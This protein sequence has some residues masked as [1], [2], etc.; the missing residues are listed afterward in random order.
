MMNNKPFL[1]RSWRLF[2]AACLVVALAACSKNEAPP[3]DDGGGGDGGDDYPYETAAPVR[4][5]RIGWDYSTRERLCPLPGRVIQYSSYPR[6]KLLSDGTLACIYEVNQGIEFIRQ[7]ADGEWRSPV[8]L[9]S[10]TYGM[11]YCVPELLELSDGTLLGMY[12]PRPTIEDV[13]RKFAIHTKRSAD[14]GATW[15]DHRVVYEASHKGIDGCWEP[16][17]IELPDGEVQL[18]FANEAPYTASSEQEIS[19]CSSR[20]G[21]LS[22]SEAKKICFVARARDGMPVPVYDA[23][24]GEILVAIEDNSAGKFR[25]SIVRTT[26]PALNWSNAPVG[27]PDVYRNSALSYTIATSAAAA[28][29]YL[30]KLPTGEYALSYQTEEGRSQPTME[31]AI[32]KVDGR[33]FTRRSVPFSIA[34]DRG[35]AVECAGGDRSARDRGGKLD[36][37]VFERAGGVDGPGADH[38]RVRGG[39]GLGDGRWQARR[40]GLAG[41]PRFLCRQ[42]DG[43]PGL[44]RALLRCRQPL[45]RGPAAD[46]RAHGHLYRAPGTRSAGPFGDQAFA[47]DLPYHGHDGRGGFGRRGDR[48]ALVRDRNEG[49]DRQR[50]RDARRLYDGG[51]SAARF[52]GCG[53]G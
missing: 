52:A 53:R 30:V 36:D 51:R 46:D 8:V 34:G 39:A 7:N 27:K 50:G 21:G 15:T 1:R 16:A 22:W 42:R 6:V 31:V 18:Y 11:S 19:M 14:G 17:A 48:D 44:C 28:A 2:A 38:A 26:Y 20:D 32:G 9:A 5:S 37:R 24:R 29:P 4:G 10:P 3:P 45:C 23:E 12:N 33:S 47:R 25:P 35:G 49:G 13:T 43:Q 40:A 41:C